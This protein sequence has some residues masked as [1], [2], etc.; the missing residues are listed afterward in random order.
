MPRTARNVVDGGVYHILNRG[1][2]RQRVFHRD[3]E[4]LEFED[5]LRQLQEQFEIDIY[6]YCLMP[7]HFHLLLKT[8]RGESLSQGMQWFTT[9]YVRRYHRLRRSSGHVWQGRYKSFAIEDD[10]HFLTVARYIEGNPVRA[11]MVDTATDWAWSS[12]R[13]RLNL[14]AA[15]TG[16]GPAGAPGTGSAGACPHHQG[17]SFLAPLPVAFTESWMEFVDTPLTGKELGQVKKRVDRQTKT[18][19][20]VGAH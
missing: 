1:N 16:A 18:V 17:Q 2:G 11:G 19:E 6:A 8:Y 15:T 10:D 14:I 4:Y 3:A 7:N 9:T 13:D 20:G 12:H 5:L